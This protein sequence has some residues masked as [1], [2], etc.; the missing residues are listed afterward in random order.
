MFTLHNGDC[1]DFLREI[2]RGSVNLIVTDPPY[3]IENMSEY[4]SLMLEAL[5]VNGSIYVFG[6]KNMVAEH[7]FRQLKIENKEILTWYYKNSP[8]P[9]G[10]WR[11][12]QQSIIYGYREGSY[13]DENSARVE[14]SESAKKLHGRMR[15]SNGRM[16]K[17]KPYKTD[18]GALPRDVIECPALL[19]H[20]AKE[21]LGHP[22]Q[23][24][25][26]LIEKIIMASSKPDD[27][28]LDCFMGSGTTIEAA[29]RT[30]RNSIGIEK[31]GG[32]F[33]MAVLRL[34]SFTPSNTTC[35]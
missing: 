31:D 16:A 4:F 8:K 6:N 3:E 15:P 13:F 12:S 27:L 26:S 14:Y 1:R 29:E 28:V 22:D 23:K 10:R 33:R 11:M 21:R 34:K 7:W 24:P 25:I 2:G 5:A 17:Q 18:V 35:T 30:G 32:N 19:G 20:L 9:K